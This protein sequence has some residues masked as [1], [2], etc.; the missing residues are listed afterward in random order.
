MNYDETPEC[1][2][3]STNIFLKS[4]WTDEIINPPTDT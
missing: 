2:S 4:H 3:L 1:L